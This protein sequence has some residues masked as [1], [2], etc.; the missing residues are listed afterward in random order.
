MNPIYSFA[1]LYKL[2]KQQPDSPHLLGYQIDSSSEFET[3]STDEVLSKI[4]FL[5]LGL[6]QL[7]V[8]KGDM[9]GILAGSSPM[10]VVADI[11][12]TLSRA[13]SVPLFANISHEN[14]EFEMKQ[15]EM[16]YLFVAGK[17]QWEMYEKH[18]NLIE[19]AINLYDE[20]IKHNAHRMKEVLEL[21]KALDEKDPGAFER[22]LEEVRPD[23]LASIVYTS[24]S[25]GVPKGVMLTH[26]NLVALAHVDPFL[27][28]VENDL[29]LS[30][31][32]LAHIFGRTVNYIVMAKGVSIYYLRDIKSV[33]AVCKELHPTMIVLVPRLLEKI[34]SKMVGKVQN[35]GFLKRTIGEWAFNLANNE[36]DDSLYKHL[37]HPIA[38]KVVYKTLREALGGKLRIVLSGGAALNPHLYHFYLDIGL[39]LYEG[40]GMT[41]ACPIG[42]NPIGKVKIGTV[43]PCFEGM[44]AKISP[45]G[46]ILI[47]GP[48][49]MIGYYKNPEGTKRAIDA[50]GWLHT[51]D[52]GEIDADGYVT[53][54]GRMKELFKLSTGKFIA[55]VPIEQ[56]LAKVPFVDM[57]LA[58]VEGRS[59]VTCLL[60]PDLEVL[61]SLKAE[62]GKSDMSYEEFL[63]SDFIKE[64]MERLLKEINSH[65]SHWEEVRDYRFITVPPSI[66]TGE[67]T[68]TMKLRRDYVM[69][70]YRDLIEDMY[71]TGER[72]YNEEYGG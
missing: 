52:K 26:H 20:E 68:P 58:I 67:L 51:G 37:L 43:G 57:A 59:Y 15:T 50:D 42:L 62:Q 30:I 2:L 60:F 53:I 16:K 61:D 1:E 40:W 64:E 22:M 33:G 13:V 38:E 36:D 69:N 46:E 10:W 4:K 3:L 54:L 31:L 18:A 12:I 9:I 32:P 8:K 71:K 24:G 39:P 66:E 45:E 34:Y 25:T 70:K 65:L 63:K 55:P 19:V 48:N 49:K 5:T 11:A 72:E 17:E 28:D 41:E 29:F 35:A 56:S 27:F 14:Y 47:K 23:D 6:K 21:G 7:G 44:E